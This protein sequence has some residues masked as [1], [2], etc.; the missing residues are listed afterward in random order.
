MGTYAGPTLD[1]KDAEPDGIAANVV[2]VANSTTYYNMNGQ[3]VEASTRGLILMRQ[4]MTDGSFRS[5]KII[6]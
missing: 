3:Q 4:Q 5:A 1:F 6:R 2:R